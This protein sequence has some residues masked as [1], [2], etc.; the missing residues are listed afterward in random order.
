M[1][2]APQFPDPM[3]VREVVRPGATAH[4]AGMDSLRRI[5]ALEQGAAGRPGPGVS[6]GSVLTSDTSQTGGNRWSSPVQAAKINLDPS[7]GGPNNTVSGNWSKVPLGNERFTTKGVTFDTTNKRL[8]ITRAGYYWVSC[9]VGWVP[10]TG[11][12]VTTIIEAWI[13]G[14]QSWDA[15]DMR[16]KG[17]QSSEAL[18]PAPFVAYFGVGTTIELQ[19]YQDSGGNLQYISDPRITFLA[20]Y[21][22][23]P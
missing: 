22:S 6:N 7:V 12:G 5:Q 21:G 1:T 10:N 15:N 9:S 13:N 20:L 23:N 17:L 14:A 4:K 8:V 3:G 16:R 18:A 19:V 11:A 2:G